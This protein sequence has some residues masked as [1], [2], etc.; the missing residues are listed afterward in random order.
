LSSWGLRQVWPVLW[1][2]AVEVL[3]LRTNYESGA[4]Y[5][6]ALESSSALDDVAVWASFVKS[7][8]RELEMAL[9]PVAGGFY[10][11]AVALAAEHMGTGRARSASNAELDADADVRCV[12]PRHVVRPA[13]TN[14]IRS[15][16][17][18]VV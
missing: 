9:I 13:C 8:L 15:L 18:V 3:A 5:S 7:W 6:V 10:E 12:A 16:L 14:V 2:D 11:R 1:Q 17:E 4:E